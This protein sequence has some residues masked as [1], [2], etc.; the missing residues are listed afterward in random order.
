MNILAFDTSGSC[1]SAGILR[2]NNFFEKNHFTGLR[3]SE[4]LLPIIKDLLKDAELK[5]RDLD[6]IVCSKG[7]GSFTGLRIGMSTA[8]GL[9][10]GSG[11][12]LVSVSSLD[13]FAF[14]LEFFNGVVVP[15]ID[16]RKKRYYA[17]VFKGGS[18][19]SD[20]LDISAYD[21]LQLTNKYKSV[22][23]TGPDADKIKND[24]IDSDSLR[25]CD[26]FYITVFGMSRILAELG[27]KVFSER[28]ADPDD[29]GPVYIR[30]SDAEISAAQRSKR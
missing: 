11:I 9:S 16:A 14:G 22:L 5:I 26:S 4:Q 30:K 24:F 21:L 19:E 18:A 23:F 1:L 20:F 13:C 27:R 8:K 6:L 15:V 12:P 25:K 29:A 17:S 7:P 3:H 2:D 28:G 10:A